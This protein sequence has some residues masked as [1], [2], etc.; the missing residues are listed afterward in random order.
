MLRL[1]CLGD[2]LTAPRRGAPFARCGRCARV[3]RL[4]RV[5]TRTGLARSTIYVR[6]ADGSFPQPIRL[7]SRAVGW[8]ESE[9]D[10]WIREQIAAS[11]G[12]AQL[13]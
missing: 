8:I 7:G 5:Q 2:L 9:V 1:G 4:P 13:I 12:R 3:L 10:A 11:R 6:V